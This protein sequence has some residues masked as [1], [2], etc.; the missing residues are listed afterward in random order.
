MPCAPLGALLGEWGVGERGRRGRSRE[1]IP[2]FFTRAERRRD[3]ARDELKLPRRRQRACCSTLAAF[4]RRKNTQTLFAAFQRLCIAGSPEALSP[5]R[6]SV[7][8]S[9]AEAWSR[10][11]QK[12]TGAVTWLPYC[13]DRARTRPPIPRGGPFRPSRRAGNL[14]A[15]HAGEPGVRYARGGHPR[16]LHGPHR[17]Q[18]SG[19]L[20][21]RERARNPSP[22]AIERH[23]PG[24]TC[25]RSAG[26]AAR[27][28]RS[29]TTGERVFDAS[30]R[31]LPRR[32]QPFSIPD[33]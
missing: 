18:R 31:D 25:A 8:A 2:P 19:T 22:N 15:R 14:R 16:Q 6:W 13:S 32:D 33:E 12:K 29:A 5:P 24:R 26:A 7:T 1:S 23:E 27:S 11:W 17:V 20:G 28:S 9:S 3:S 4:R 30:V 10:R 21:G